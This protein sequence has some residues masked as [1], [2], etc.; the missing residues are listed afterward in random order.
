MFSTLLAPLVDCAP[1]APMPRSWWPDTPRVG[2][3]HCSRVRSRPATLPDLDVRG[4]AALAPATSPSAILDAAPTLSDVL[5]FAAMTAEGI[6]AAFPRADVD[7]IL[8]PEADAAVE[9]LDAVAC[10]FTTLAGFRDQHITVLRADPDS[11]PSVRE[12]LRRSTAGIVPTRVPIVVYQG[13]Q[14]SLVQPAVT[15]AYVFRACA[16]GDHLSAR[17]IPRP[18]TAP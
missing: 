2:R 10:L 14:D 7:A 5:G 15:A 11:V 1:P 13:A 3:L 9:R 12:A 8:T 16:L 4:V 6:R 17:A 18:T